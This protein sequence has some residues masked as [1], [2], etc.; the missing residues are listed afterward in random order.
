MRCTRRGQGQARWSQQVGE[1]HQAGATNAARRV[2]APNGGAPPNMATLVQEGQPA[3]GGS[4]AGVQAVEVNSRLSPLAWRSPV[5]LGGKSRRALLAAMK[6]PAQRPGAPA[7]SCEAGPLPPC[8]LGVTGFV[9]V[10]R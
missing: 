4:A 8:T 9:P 3:P 10:V 5:T 6:E 7:A 2:T 1:G